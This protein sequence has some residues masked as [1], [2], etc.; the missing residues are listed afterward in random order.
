MIYYIETL[1]VGESGRHEQ[2]FQGPQSVA[3]F[4]IFNKHS[5]HHPQQHLPQME[6]HQV[7]STPTTVPIPQQDVD[8]ERHE[9]ASTDRESEIRRIFEQGK[10]STIIVVKRIYKF[11]VVVT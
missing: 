6:Y 7:T 4:E 2:R 10:I 3:P 5:T 11:L 9:S 1:E 8:R